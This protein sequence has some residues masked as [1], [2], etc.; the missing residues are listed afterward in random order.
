MA[1]WWVTEALPIAITALL[2]VA[3]LPL[4][5]IR[6]IEEAAAPY[7]NPLI[8][9]FLGGFILA[10]AIQRWGLHRRLSLLVLSLSGTRPDRVIAGFMVATAGLSMW[11][12]N[13]ATAALMLPIALSVLNLVDSGSDDTAQKNLSLCL[14]LGIAMSANIGG[15]ATIIG[16]P[17]NAIL[18]GYLSDNHGINISFGE[19]MLVAFPLSV[20]LLAIAWWFLTRIIYPVAKVELSGLSVL[21]DDERQSLGRM[22]VP[23]KAVATVFVL[24]AFAWLSRPWIENHFPGIGLSDAGIAI[25]GALLLF[26][27][28]AEWR[29][30]RF[31]MDWET[32]RKLPWGVLLLVGGGLSLGSAIESSGLAAHAAEALYAL[33]GLQT[34]V[35]MAGVITLIMLLSHVTSN[36]AT[37]ATMLPLASSLALALEIPLLFLTIPVAMAASCAFML[38]VA[39]PPNAIIFSSNRITVPQMVSAGAV[40]SL[41]TIPLI[42][43]WVRLVMAPVLG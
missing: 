19:W 21:L 16:T 2:P 1:I 7:A 4:L 9:L 23:E 6:P 11:V 39:T 42:L 31:L 22:I 20:L 40:I 30:L 33:A 32:A 17:P 10:E 41:L 28:P 12:S 8:F 34:W 38:P 3:L 18:A 29:R 26:V 43:L 36:T 35:I 27:I 24:V 13:T 37:A 25:L 14:L 15:M 5:D